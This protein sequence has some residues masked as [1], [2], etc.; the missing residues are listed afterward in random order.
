MLQGLKDSTSR[1]IEGIR[2]RGR[3]VGKEVRKLIEKED[4]WEGGGGLLSDEEAEPSTSKKNDGEA[5]QGKLPRVSSGLL[6]EADMD[7][8]LEKES[9]GN[10]TI[11]KR[12][13]RFA[14]RRTN[15]K[16]LTERR[17][18]LSLE[19]KDG[20]FTKEALA[21]SS[22]DAE[23]FNLD[24]NTTR[25][26]S[27]EYPLSEPEDL[28]TRKK[29]E[30]SVALPLLDDSPLQRVA[31][32][33]TLQLFVDDTT[34]VE[35][36]NLI[37][38]EPEM[39]KIESQQNDTKLPKIPDDNMKPLA[40]I[41][42][43]LDEYQRLTSIDGM[44]EI[45]STP[46]GDKVKSQLKAL[47]AII[48]QQCQPDAAERSDTAAKSPGGLFY[49]LT[50]LESA[51]QSISFTLQARIKQAEQMKVDVA[52]LLAAQK[53]EI[54]KVQDFHMSIMKANYGLQVL[55]SRIAEAEEGTTAFFNRLNNVESK[56][57]S[58]FDN[59]RTGRNQALH[60]VS[61]LGRVFGA[62]KRA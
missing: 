21:R 40:P 22:V 20:A 5:V 43:L 9:T 1:T 37:V 55:D 8:G 48:E 60:V 33:P 26:V 3:N 50:R 17:T 34:T 23:V 35:P 46:A 41:Q 6:S 58:M 49:R 32:A 62:E 51:H 10:A 30:S 57:T 15:K 42:D 16:D 29:D 7:S 56:L 18:S 28:L 59:N 14:L 44:D 13:S 61:G 24:V 11:N 52:Q 54:F 19:T 25:R 27:A 45:L 39:G 2:E 4:G 36:S 38:T 31:S 12:R 53:A 47:V